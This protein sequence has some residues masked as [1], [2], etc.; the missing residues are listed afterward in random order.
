[1]WE[2]NTREVILSKP[3]TVYFGARVSFSPDGLCIVA[4]SEHSTATI[5][6]VS[7]GIE[8]VIL[9][10]HDKLVKS[11]IYSSNG[12]QIVTGSLDFHQG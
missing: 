4:P 2:L 8:K 11:A 12:A 9:I 3:A 5:W 1:V 6:D 7:T 10:G